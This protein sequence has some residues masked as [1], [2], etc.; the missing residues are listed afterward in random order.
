[1]AKKKSK[2]GFRW[3]E[4]VLT[5]SAFGFLQKMPLSLAY[6][7]GRGI[8]W[9][10]FKLL[11][12]RRKVVRRNLETIHAWAERHGG[13]SMPD[14]ETHIREV[15]LCNG[16]NFFSG[17]ALSGMLTGRIERHIEVVG[18]EALQSAIADGKGAILVLA[19]MGPWEALAHL[20]ELFARNGI[21]TS[22]ASMYRPFNDDR[23]D[24]WYRTVR[25]KC[26]TRMLSRKD[27][28]H[29]PVDFIRSNGVLGVLSDQKMRQGEI[30]PFFGVEVPT[31]PITGLFYRR[32]GAP[33]F[34][35]CFK[36]IGPKQWR[37][38]FERVDCSGLSEK[39]TRSELAL[40]CNEALER[41]LSNSVPDGF[42]FHR[43]FN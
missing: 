41:V 39:P 24:D 36:T 33:I 34:S 18:A 15:F 6:R 27:G 37:I 11:K 30:V 4:Y 13:L 8:G 17:F 5:R 1:M 31:S 40:L 43:R 3:L 22:W 42:W 23:F 32:T 7:L 14:L 19:H 38:T 28:F 29:K 9:L 35:L 10:S 21:H 25:E 12:G 16:A 20:P 26:G 2:V